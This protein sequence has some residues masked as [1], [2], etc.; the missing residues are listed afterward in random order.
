MW[1]YYGSKTNLVD[2]YPAP[3]YD[4]IIE[5]FAGAAKYSLKYFEKEVILIDKYPVIIEIWEWLKSCSEK[6][7][8]SLPRNLKFGDRLDDINFDCQEQK[9]FYGFI[10][11][12]GAE[13]PRRSAIKRKTTERP[14]HINHNLKR[15]AKN[16][17]KIRH[18][19]FKCCDYK[20]SDILLLAGKQ[21]TYFIDPPYQFGGHSYVHSNKKIDFTELGEWCKSRPGQVIVC[22]NTK[23]NWLPFIPISDNR[24]SLF[25]TTEA[26]WTNYHTHYNNIQQTLAL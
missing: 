3:I 2:L 12:C 10:I 24:G 8:L 6:D 22:E 19:Q 18:W 9:D 14:N 25:M 23:A 21:C 13:K 15:V 17:Y 5:P 7:I 26:I 1:S 4:T 16:L 20:L 11:G